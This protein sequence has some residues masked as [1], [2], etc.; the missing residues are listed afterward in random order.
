[1]HIKSAVCHEAVNIPGLGMV[2]TLMLSQTV[3]L[4]AL[5]IGI[6]Y[7]RTGNDICVMVPYNNIKYL[8]VEDELEAC[9]Q[10]DTEGQATDDQG[11]QAIRGPVVADTGAAGAFSRDDQA[12][13]S[14][15]GYQPKSA[16][17]RKQY[18]KLAFRRAK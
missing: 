2:V 4:E 13:G 18:E 11:S 1:M 12:Q 14:Q 5:E 7:K 17:A 6:L 15:G 8:V 16:R 3:S 9:S 10:A